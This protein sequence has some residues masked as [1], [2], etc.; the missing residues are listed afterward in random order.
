MN[1]LSPGYFKTMRIPLLE[2]RDFKDSDAQPMPDNPGDMHG[3]AIVNRRFA[4]HFFP[5]QSAVGK[6]IGWGGGPKAKL[7][8][9]IVGVAAD[10]LYEGPREGVHRQV[11]IPFYGKNSSVFY[12]RTL[13]SSAAT[14][15]QIRNEVHQLDSAIPVYGMKTVEGQLDETLLTDRLIAML[16]A[17]FGVLAT[18]LASIGLYGVM[19]FVVARRKKELGIRLALGA[20]PRIVVWMVMREVLLLLAIGLAVGIPSAMALGGYVGSQ[21]YGIQPHDPA[22][23]GW[24]VALLTVVSTLAGLIP[25]TRASQ[26]DPILALRTE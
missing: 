11:F 18:L 10:S 13:A 2:G 19:A 5:G 25:A 12:L 7:N 9:E 14:Y 24:T 16:S 8:L 22:I 15:G 21:L 3:V 17:G 26:I 1:A 6:H 20:Q 4:E 23:A